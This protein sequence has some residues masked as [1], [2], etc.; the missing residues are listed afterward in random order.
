MRDSRFKTVTKRGL[1]SVGLEVRRTVSPTREDFYPVVDTCQVKNLSF[2]FELF[3]GS[4]ENGSFVEV[5]AYDGITYSNTWGLAERGWTG[6]L[7][8]PVPALAEASKRNHVNHLKVSVQ[9]KAIGAQEDRIQLR[10]AGP[11]TTADPQ[12][13]EDYEKVEWAARWMTEEVIEVEQI[14]LDAALRKSSIGSDFDVL[15]VD[16]EGHEMPVFEGFSLARWT[17][18]MMIVELEDVHPVLHTNRASHARLTQRILTEG[19]GIVYKD[20]VNTVF[21]RQDVLSA[22]L[23]S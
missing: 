20:S 9:Q 18:K 12:Q 10:L 11:Y 8:E 22:A 15:V 17:P 21:V 19:Y 6:L 1:A 3:L 14:T 13:A 7:L 2:I 23:S 16:V 5:G 4:R